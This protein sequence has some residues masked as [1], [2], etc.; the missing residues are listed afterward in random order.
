VC[1]PKSSLILPL[2]AGFARCRIY[3]SG[4]LE[5]YHESFFVGTGAVL[6]SS[7]DYNAFAPAQFDDAITEPNADAALQY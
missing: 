5:T 6:D 7:E 4:G 2:C 1:E 3:D